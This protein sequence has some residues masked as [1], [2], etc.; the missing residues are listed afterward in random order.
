M[1]EKYQIVLS[2]EEDFARKVAL[3]VIVTKPLTVWHYLIPGMF[4]IDFLRRG[5][6]IKR[7][8]DHFIFPRKVAIEVA[9]D[10]MHGAQKDDRMSK[11]EKEIKG[12]LNS[13]EF[14]SVALES[15]QIEIVKSLVEHYRTLFMAE[16]DSY[17]TL[18]RNAYGE[19]GKYEAHLSRLTSLEMEVDKAIIETLGDSEGLRQR[20]VA[21]QQ[22]LEK[23][24]GK[25]VEEIFFN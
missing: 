4:I 20:L 12:W 23:M 2:A 11:A 18:I 9:R 17:S 7:Y 10:I 14:Y 1:P 24:R 25:A 3:G 5:S 13:L 21:E 16:G 22:Q 15:A 6:V 19:R 8:S